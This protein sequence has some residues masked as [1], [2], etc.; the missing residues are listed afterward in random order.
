MCGLFGG[1]SNWLTAE[2][3]K[4]VANLGILSNFRGRDSTGIGLVKKHKKGMGYAIEKKAVP[5]TVFFEN[6]DTLKFLT[7]HA[8]PQAIL[9]HTR[10]TTTGKITES[11][12]HP[13]KFG[14]I[15]GVHNGQFG[16]YVDKSEDHSD[17]YNF[18]EDVSKIGMKAALD[19]AAKDDLLAYALV[20][21]DFSDNTLNFV[22][23]DQRPLFFM[24]TLDA[25]T[26]FWASERGFLDM[27]ARFSTLKFKQ[28]FF[29]EAHKHVKYNL[30][31]EKWTWEMLKP[32]IPERKYTTWSAQD[33]MFNNDAKINKWVEEARQRRLREEER[34][35]EKKASV[36]AVNNKPGSNVIVLGPTQ[37]KKFED[38]VFYSGYRHEKWSSGVAAAR[39]SRGCYC[40]KKVQVISDT[41]Y[42]RTEDKYLCKSCFEDPV[43]IA[44]ESINDEF[45]KYYTESKCIVEASR[46]KEK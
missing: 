11:N 2:E 24:E 3:V 12:A 17:S 39:L 43:V 9:G 45:A 13:F 16:A 25:S 14:N 28:P 23:N 32:A 7:K 30:K 40:C 27:V 46:V 38:W 19:K 34:K 33:S 42:W 1:V 22:R 41:V 29:M 21:V 10:A 31:T 44:V 6:A 36:P 8:Q 35:K 15:L 18:Y 4:F 26:T 5:S 20:W 37:P